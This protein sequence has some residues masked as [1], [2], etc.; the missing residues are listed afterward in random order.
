MRAG[1]A[2]VQGRRPNMEDRVQAKDVKTVGGVELTVAVVADGIGGGPHGEKAAELTLET[3]FDEI[4]RSP[5]TDSRQ[6]PDL[7]KEAV[8][9]ANKAVFHMA[10]ENK[11]WRGM[12]S[13]ATVVVV[14]RQQRLYIANL[15]DSRIYLARGGEKNLRQLTRDHTWANE[16]VSRNLLPA[17]EAKGHPRAAELVRSIGHQAVVA[18]DLGLYVNGEETEEQASTQQGYQLHS[19]D[20]VVLCSDGLIKTRHNAPGRHYVEDREMRQIVTCRPPEQA[21]QALVNKAVRRDVDD[22]VSVIVLEAPGSRRASRLA[23]LWPSLQPVAMA[24]IALFVIMLPF[25]FLLNNGT[26]NSPATDLFG[27]TTTAALV[28]MGTSSNTPTPEP[29]V[30]A[31]IINVFQAGEGAR[32]IAEGENP[33]RVSVGERIQFS[34]RLVLQ[35]GDGLVELRLPDHTR[36]FLA[37]GTEIQIDAVA[38]EGGATTTA[39]SV[40][41][42]RVVAVTEQTDLALM[43]SFGWEAQLVEVGSVLGLTYNPEP[44]AEFNFELVCFAG[45]CRL[46]GDEGR[47]ILAAEQ[48]GRIGANGR[49]ALFS[50]A[51]YELYYPLA[52]AIVPAPTATATP[53]PTKTPLPTSTPARPTSTPSP[54]AT[55]VPTSTIAPTTIVESPEPPPPPSEEV[56]PTARP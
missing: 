30:E 20:R 17:Q 47:T 7:L 53:T 4:R 9:K 10:N 45:R 37:A 28:T 43:N 36:L 5:L 42:A 29:T 19:D 38:G 48:A 13:T 11:Q 50:P 54:V 40:E 55:P 26:A 12:G 23:C 24:S 34:P 18:V 6:V 25:I 8:E 44:G 41:Q 21:A 22:N 15:G 52:P 16:V 56:P 39:I 3:I 51:H 46:V 31:G 33:K 1:A 14:D 2:M 32:W 35:A 27:V 49:P